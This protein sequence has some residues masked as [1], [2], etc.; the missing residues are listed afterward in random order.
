MR[1]HGQRR[2]DALFT[3]EYDFQDFQNE[4]EF[5]FKTLKEFIK[6]RNQIQSLNHKKA[7]KWLSSWREILCK[8]LDKRG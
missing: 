5:E 7:M 1:K 2:R 4:D 3:H 8:N 6:K